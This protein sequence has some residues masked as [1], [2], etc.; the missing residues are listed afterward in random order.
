MKSSNRSGSGPPTSTVPL[1]GAASATSATAAA[2]SSAAIG[3]TSTGG[4]RAVSPS[5]A[6]SAM[7]RANSKNWVACTI[8]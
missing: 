6:S 2:T 8:V 3:W 5:V 1:R 4:T 7:R